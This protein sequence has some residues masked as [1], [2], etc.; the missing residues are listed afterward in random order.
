MSENINPNEPQF[1][2]KKW[3]ISDEVQE[4]AKVK[5]KYFKKPSY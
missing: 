5:L 1:D 3:V 2:N 4:R